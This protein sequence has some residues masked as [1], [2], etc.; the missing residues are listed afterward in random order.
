MSIKLPH[1]SIEFK[2]K[3]L[4]T[5]NFICQRGFF[6]SDFA[7][8]AAALYSTNAKYKGVKKNF[9]FDFVSDFDM[10]IEGKPHHVVL[11]AQVLGNYDFTS[12]S[13]GVCGGSAEL[14]RR[15]HFD[16]VHDNAGKKQKV[17]VSHIQYGGRSGKGFDGKQFLTNN[18][19]H[20]LSEP[21]IN[22]PPINLALLLDLIFCEFFNE[23][24]KKIVENSEWRGL[25]KDNETFI[26]G[27]YYKTISDHIYSIRHSKEVLVRDVCY[28]SSTN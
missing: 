28:G 5:L 7:E 25:I 3:E 10:E 23:K 19:E 26:F 18:I 21:R 24:T 2:K 20:W 17:P 9:D 8:L 15:F 16:Y 1:S 6:D 11:H 12:Y 22:Y 14:I 4:E 13:I 27:H